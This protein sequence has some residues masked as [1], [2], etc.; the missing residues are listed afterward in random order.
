MDD[1]DMKTE[2]VAGEK[3]S[4]DDLKKFESEWKTKS[5]VCPHCGYCP[6]CG[7]PYSFTPNVPY[8]P[9]WPWQG[10]FYCGT[11]TATSAMS[12]RNC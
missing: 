11:P 2:N 8:Y 4:M 12:N 1:N 6:S 10:P 9:A 5:S 7:R 3:I